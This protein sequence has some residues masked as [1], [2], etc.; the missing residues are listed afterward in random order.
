MK[1]KRIINKRTERGIRSVL[2]Y[3]INTIDKKSKKEIYLYGLISK[4]SEELREYKALRDD[5]LPWLLTTYV[6]SGRITVEQ[7]ES[8]LTQ[9]Q[10][11]D[12]E[13]WYMAFCI[14]D[15]LKSY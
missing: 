5:F 6:N 7:E 14:I 3:A 8:L 2:L 12:R 1:S 11:P 15:N 13:A 9:L 4:V 10:S